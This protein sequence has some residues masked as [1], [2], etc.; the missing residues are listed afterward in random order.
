MCVL[1]RSKAD[2]VLTNSDKVEIKSDGSQ[3]SL[4]LKKLGLDDGGQYT[5]KAQNE[6]GETSC[7]ATLLVHGQRPQQL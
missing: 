3:Y 2:V 5:I 1:T 6:V 7:T 4:I